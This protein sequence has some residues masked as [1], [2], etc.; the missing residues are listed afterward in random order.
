[1]SEFPEVTTGFN[2]GGYPLMYV[3]DG[4][5]LCGPCASQADKD[6]QGGL[7]QQTHWEGPAIDCE[8][9]GVSIES[10]Y[11]DPEEGD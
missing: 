8:E 3:G 6:V 1:M 2:S 7:V 5:V 10:A 4:Y 9:C 11:G